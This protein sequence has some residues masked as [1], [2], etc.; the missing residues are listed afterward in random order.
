MRHCRVQCLHTQRQTRG[1]TPDAAG[2]TA[3]RNPSPSTHLRHSTTSPFKCGSFFAVELAMFTRPRS[4]LN[5]VLCALAVAVI[6]AMT[7]MPAFAQA[8][9]TQK[10]DAVLQ[11]RLSQLRGRSR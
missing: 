9:D 2:T 7:S 11:S 3:V 6:I 1:F 5:A 8:S 10:L 4:V